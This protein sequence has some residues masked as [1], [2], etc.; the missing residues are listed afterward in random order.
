MKKD[1]LIASGKLEMY[2]NGSLGEEE[3]MEI[4]QAI[5]DHPEVKKEVELI[6]I[7]YMSLGEALAPTIPAMVWT[8]I[9]QVTGKVKRLGSSGG[10]KINWGAI[11]GW[12]AAIVCIGGI[13]W[14]LDQNNTL[15]ENIQ[16][17]TN[18]NTILKDKTEAIQGE[19]TEVTDLLK[20]LGSKNYNTYTLPG[21]P[22]VAPTAF[23]K[24]HYS[25]SENIAY[26]D[27]KGL[28]APPEGKVYQVWSLIM[29]P[30]TPTSVGLLDGYSTSQ[31]ETGIFKFENIAS[32]DAFG[33]TLEPE[34]GSQSPTL[35]E[36][37]TIGNITP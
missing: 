18:E 28:P 37:Y 26:I 19:L 7:T 1:E 5:A 24:V 25:E 8:K 22:E 15:E 2:V 30:L 33:I 9:L 12:A 14:M 34:G 31:G 6:E 13:F 3:V 36:L 32:L 4:R 29:E 11:S 27:A 17:T 20:I 10:S 23:A 16:L 21:N 35:S